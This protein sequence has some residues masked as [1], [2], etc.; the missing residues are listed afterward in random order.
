M[1][2]S[3]GFRLVLSATGSDEARRR[4]RSLGGYSRSLDQSDHEVESVGC[5]SNHPL[6]RAKAQKRRSDWSE[7][8]ERATSARPSLFYIHAHQHNTS[9]TTA[10]Q[11]TTGRTPHSDS[12]LFN[13]GRHSVHHFPRYASTHTQQRAPTTRSRSF[14]TITA[15]LPVSRIARPQNGA[16]SHTTINSHGRRATPPL[17]RTAAQQR[18]DA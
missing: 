9:I 11:L 14:R 8:D 15:A 10:Q 5:P 3:T 6:P 12:L 13:H 4:G 2:K 16:P 18:T 7:R 1:S 17:P